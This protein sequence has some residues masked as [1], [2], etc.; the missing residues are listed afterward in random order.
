MELSRILEKIFGYS[1]LQRTDEKKME[2][3]YQ[4]VVVV[5]YYEGIEYVLL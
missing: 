4:Q 5:V 3:S 1:V 2:M